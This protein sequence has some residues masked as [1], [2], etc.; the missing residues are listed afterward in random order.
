MITFPSGANIP[1]SAEDQETIDFIKN[2][3]A[4]PA[5]APVE[6]KA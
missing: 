3:S 4:S 1:L 5:P 2:K 6:V